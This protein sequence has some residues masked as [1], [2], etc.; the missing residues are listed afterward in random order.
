MSPC[1]PSALSQPAADAIQKYL[2]AGE[3]TGWDVIVITNGTT[4]SSLIDLDYLVKL[5]A[6]QR[7]NFDSY[8]S[9]S[10]KNLS[11]DP[12]NTYTAASASAPPPSKRS[13]AFSSRCRVRKHRP[14]TWMCGPKTSWLRGSRSPCRP[15]LRPG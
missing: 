9:D 6:D 14:T 11:Y 8:V 12:H 3:P 5:P 1:K 2:A 10:V 15:L 4:L 7:P 13:A